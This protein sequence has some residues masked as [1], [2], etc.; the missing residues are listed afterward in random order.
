MAIDRLVSSIEKLKVNRSPC[1]I[2]GHGY[3]LALSM[4]IASYLRARGYVALATLPDHKPFSSNAIRV[5]VSESARKP[6]WPTSILIAH[7]TANSTW[8]ESPPGVIIRVESDSS[9]AWLPCD[10]AISVLGINWR[11]SKIPLPKDPDAKTTL[12][13]DSCGPDAREYILAASKKIDGINLEALNIA[14]FGHGYHSSLLKEETQGPLVFCLPDGAHSRKWENVYNWVV[15]NAN[16]PYIH[17]ITLP[18]REHSAEYALSVGVTATTMIKD[19]CNERGVDIFK[20]PI[21]LH[22]DHLR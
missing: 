17:Q 5:L 4:T 2:V 16:V 10:F 9:G 18:G 19:H 3:S 6:S 20:C 22:L 8:M 14:E 21:P 11:P 13:F 7:S 15:R 12:I 1:E